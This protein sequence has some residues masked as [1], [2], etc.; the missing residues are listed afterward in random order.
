[1]RIA[2]RRSS[3]LP[4]LCGLHP[5]AQTLHLTCLPDLPVAVAALFADAPDTTL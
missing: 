2:L 3:T 4:A 1:L 5:H